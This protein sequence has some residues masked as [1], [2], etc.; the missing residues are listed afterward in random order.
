[1][2][3]VQPENYVCECPFPFNA[4]NSYLE[5]SMDSNHTKSPI[6]PFKVNAQAANGL[7]GS[8]R[9]KMWELGAACHCPLV[10]TCWHVDDLRRLVNKSMGKLVVADDYNVHV[11]AVTE[12]RQRN[13]LSELL[14]RDLDQRHA[15]V[16]RQFRAAKSSDELALLWKKTLEQGDASGAL[17]A[18]LTHPRCDDALQEVI[19]R[20]MHMFQHHAV[21]QLRNDQSE[22][23]ALVN[24][25]ASLTQELARTQD[26]SI[27]CKV[28]KMNEIEQLNAK[29]LQVH[30]LNLQK[31]SQITFLENQLNALKKETPDFKSIQRLKQKLQQM[32][33]RQVELEEQ[34]FNLR[35]KQSAN[36]E[37]EEMPEVAGLPTD[38]TNLNDWPSRL[39][40]PSAL[41][42]Q[43]KTVLCVG[44]R[45]G[46]VAS[47][48]DVIERVGG[49]FAHHDGGRED[50]T[51]VLDSNLAAADLV[52]CQTGCISHNAYWKVKDF[53]K[54]TGK[55]CVFVEN[56]STSALARSLEVM[57]AGGSTSCPLDKSNEIYSHL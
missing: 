9:R 21:S 49:R 53:C 16:I 12:C 43:Q 44:G 22:L 34:V 15:G 37:V 27:R 13:R 50:N 1:M 36:V 23:S 31:D 55:R 11:G 51:N 57:T 32:A 2:Q 47:Y 33:Q 30:T 39:P 5:Y 41:Q 40:A 14:Q 26:R 52:I 38:P 4:N 7:T 6:G 45:S 25:N 54:R 24:A 18:A 8:R 17:W 10:G 56:P 20:N 19:C 42:L 29:L 3:R 35:K 48:R 46:S 28:E